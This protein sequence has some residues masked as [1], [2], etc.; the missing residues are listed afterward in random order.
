[1]ASARDG[2]RRIGRGVGS[3]FRNHEYWWKS[4]A[5]RSLCARSKDGGFNSRIVM[6]G[7]PGSGK[8][9]YSGFISRELGG[10]S[11]L[12]ILSTGE[13]LR[14]EV[15]ADTL[16][17]RSVAEIT[18]AGELVPDEIVTDLV[19]KWIEDQNSGFI[20][21]GF[22]R[23]TAQAKALEEYNAGEEAPTTVVNIILPEDAIIAKLLGRRSCTKCG[24]SFNL[25]AVYDEETGLDMPA[26][27][28]PDECHS[29]LVSRSDDT[30]EIIRERLRVYAEETAPLVNFYRSLGVLIDFN[31]KLGIGDMPKLISKVKDH[32]R[33]SRAA[34]EW[35]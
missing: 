29:Y 2:L 10:E 20:L 7:A 18:S 31:V 15:E 32:E 9:T 12:N 34:A 3:A 17:G 16:L 1:M 5:R 33:L 23:T 4:P 6:L 28:A 19:F 26:I 11:D 35:I 21:D 8:G 22:P 27:P 30:D 25:A 14:K 13:L 24:A